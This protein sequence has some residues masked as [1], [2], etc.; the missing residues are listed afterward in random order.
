MVTTIIVRVSASIHAISILLVRFPRDSPKRV[1]NDDL[2][3]RI[4][5]LVSPS[6]ESSDELS[7]TRMR[8]GVGGAAP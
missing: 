5:Y 1:G 4:V 2:S 6:S 3:I 8:F 7:M